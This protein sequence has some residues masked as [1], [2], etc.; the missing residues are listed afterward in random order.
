MIGHKHLFAEMIELAGTVSFGD[1]FTVEVKGKGNV[2]F[3]QKNGKFRMVEDIYYIPKIKNNIL[4]VGQ[5]MEKRFK[6]FIKKRTLHLKDSRGRDIARVEMREN[7]MFKLNLQRIEKKYLKINKEDEVWLW[8]MRFRHLGYNGLRDLVKKQSVQGL[9]NFDFDNKFYEVRVITKQTRRQFGKS[10]FSVTRPLE[11]I[12]T[13]I[14]G[15]ITP[16]LFSGNEYFITF[17]DDYSRKCWVCFLEKKSKAFKTFK[18][19]KVMVE[20]TT[21]EKI[22]SL[23]SDRGGE[24]LS[25]QFKSYCENH[26]IRRFLTAP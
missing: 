1:A 5:L 8:H 15:P 21:G 7:R 9:P 14:Y 24:Y 20:K 4:S 16:Y 25:N 2:K 26:G 19:F 3:L 13:D 17:I 18:K 11:L 22:R 23:R 6:I 10:K 12:H